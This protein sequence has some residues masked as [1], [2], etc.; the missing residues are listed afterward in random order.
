MT[1]KDLATL[2]DKERFAKWGNSKQ[3][4]TIEKCWEE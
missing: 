1:K 4:S 3:Q 2:K